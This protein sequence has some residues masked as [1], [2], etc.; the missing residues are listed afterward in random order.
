M[1][2]KPDGLAVSAMMPNFI[3]IG[4]YE[5]SLVDFLSMTEY[6]LTNTDLMVNDPRIKFVKMV[7]SM[8]QVKGWAEMLGA[9]YTGSKRL[10][11]PTQRKKPAKKV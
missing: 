7:G 10:E 3:F 5:L 4:G 1:G 2:T 11:V 6:V 9:P 8:K